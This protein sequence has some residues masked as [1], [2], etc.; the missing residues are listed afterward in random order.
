MNVKSEEKQEKSAI[1][2]D[3]EVGAEECESAG[4]KV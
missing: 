2:R 1:E 3:I 4:D